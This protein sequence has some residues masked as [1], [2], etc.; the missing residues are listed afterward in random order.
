MRSGSYLEAMERRRLVSA[1]LVFALSVCFLIWHGPSFPL[2]VVT[3]V[4]GLYATTK[5]FQARRRKRDPRS[6]FEQL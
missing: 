4:A 1:F 3:T 2:L 6:P 5:L